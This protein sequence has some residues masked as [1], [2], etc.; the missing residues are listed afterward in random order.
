MKSERS[1][2]GFWVAVLACAVFAAP[3]P[4]IAGQEAG[5]EGAG[6]ARRQA[7]GEA[8]NS[9]G[10]LEAR[11]LMDKGQDLLDAQETERGVRLL[12]SVIEQYPG[13]RAVYKAS[14]VLGKH[15]LGIHEQMKAIGFLTRLKPLEEAGKVMT[16][17]EKEIFLEGA[18]LMGVG[19]FQVRQFSQAFPILRKIT[20]N[21]P[22]TIWANQAYYYIGM[23]H[24]A[25]QNWNKAIEALS[26]VGTFVDPDSP[27]ARYVEAGH[28][29]YVKV[30]DADLPILI[31]LGR[32]ITV[33]AVTTQGDREEF[34]CIPLTTGGDIEIGSLPTEIGTPKPGDG[35]LQVAGGDEITTTYGDEN[36]EDGRVNVA[37][38]NTVRVVSTAGL[39]FVLGDNETPATAAFLDQPL[40][41]LLQDADKDVSLQSDSAEISVVSR[42][43]DESEEATAEKGVDLDAIKS[44][45]K[46][47]VRDQMRIRLSETGARTGRFTGRIQIAAAAD[48]AI[49]NP[50]DQVLTCAVG[51]D[52]VATYV[53]ELHI[54]GETPRTVEGVIPVAGEIDNRPKASQDVVLDPVLRSRRN[55]VEATAYLELARIF[56][57]MGLVKG[58]REKT[59]EA[60]DRVE[61]IIR[62]GSAIPDTLKE[63]AF[64]M[65][66]ELLIVSDDLVGAMATCQLFN[67]LFPNSPFVDDALMGIAKVR[68]ERK[69]YQEALTVF[70]QVLGLPK[71]GAKAEA[72]FRI[73][74]TVDTLHRLNDG[75]AESLSPAALQEYKVCAERYPESPFAGESLS[76]LVDYYVD[77]A[78]YTQANV[79]LEQIFQDYPDAAFLDGM[80]LKWVLVC[81]RSGD[82]AK[83]RDKCSKLIFEYPES[84]FA[85]RAKDILP[86]I[87]SQLKKP[88]EGAA[89]EKKA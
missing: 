82:Y 66:W 38:T 43:R 68:L 5:T 81:Y 40:N 51:D 52:I 36:A 83:A 50:G 7:R 34:D 30:A 39:A 73:A 31:A 8:V 18:Y 25:Q 19:Y 45:K 47:K 87:E 10:E 54:G 72:Q 37:R 27:T 3:A 46:Y 13:T 64:K 15:Y 23:C 33:S 67:R 53:D 80:L 71:S 48:N 63:Q 1:D 69:E 35:V 79:L 44:E 12:E 60:L 55:L 16:D 62:G 14:L 58:A 11:R 20:N 76:K 85:Q 6:G 21:Y 29:F 4:S 61:S 41:V 56:K 88:A 26:L 9:P 89:T 77:T 32:K 78:D 59:A 70:R 74:Q 84:P 24:V 65:K 57:S 2:S 49:I 42:Y 17:A 86:K 22:N 28:R 75:S